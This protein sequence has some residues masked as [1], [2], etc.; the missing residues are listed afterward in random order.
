M[1]ASII[2][3]IFGQKL[4]INRLNH[5]QSSSKNASSLC[6]GAWRFFREKNRPREARFVYYV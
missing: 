1:H 6:C 4:L 2:Y 5:D 3:S